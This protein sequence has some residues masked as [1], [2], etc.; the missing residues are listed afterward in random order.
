MVKPK[1]RV[2]QPYV[3]Q[4]KK[5]NLRHKINRVETELEGTGRTSEN[6]LSSTGKKFQAF[7]ITEELLY[8]E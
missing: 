5:K 1:C 8:M 4:R 6:Y 3:G 7:G 2:S